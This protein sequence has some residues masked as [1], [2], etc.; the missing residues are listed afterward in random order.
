MLPCGDGTCDNG[1]GEDCET[2]A[3]DCACEIGETCNP[4]SGASGDAVCQ[5]DCNL[6]G[7]PAGDICLHGSC[8]PGPCAAA[9]N[10]DRIVFGKID[11][12]QSPEGGTPNF[13]TQQLAA[14]VASA[15]S[16]PLKSPG[17]DSDD[18]GVSADTKSVEIRK[19]LATCLSLEHRRHKLGPTMGY[20][21]IVWQR[22]GAAVGN[23]L[24]YGAL[25][26]GSGGILLPAPISSVTESGSFQVDSY[27]ISNVPTGIPGLSFLDFFNVDNFDLNS[28]GLNPATI[29][30]YMP[31]HLSIVDIE[32][33]GGGL[34]YWTLTVGYN[35]PVCG[36]DICEYNGGETCDGC[37]E[38]C[39]C[40]A[41]YACGDA[42]TGICTC[43]DNPNDGYDCCAQSEIPVSE[44]NALVE[45][46]HSL[47][48]DNWNST[49]T[50]DSEQWLLTD[51]QPSDWRGVI[52]TNNHVSELVLAW[53]NH[54]GVLP[55]NFNEYPELEV[56]MFANAPLTSGDIPSSLFDL[57]NLREVIIA[58]NG[59]GGELPTNLTNATT[60]E[61][62]WI[63]SNSNLSGKLPSGWS[64]LS[65]LRDLELGHNN[66]IGDI[67]MTF[68]DMPLLEHIVLRDNNFDGLAPRLD[69]SANLQ[70]YSISENNFSGPV[71]SFLT[72]LPNLNVI[73]A[74]SN[75]LAGLV[76][77]DLMT[78]SLSTLSLQNNGCLTAGDNTVLEA[79]LDSMDPNWDNGWT[80]YPACDCFTDTHCPAGDPVCHIASGVCEATPPTC[81][82]NICE[83]PLETCVNC[84][85]DCGCDALETCDAGIG[86]CSC[87]D[88]EASDPDVSAPALVCGGGASGGSCGAGDVD[89]FRIYPQSAA[90]PQAG[91]SDYVVAGADVVCEA[92]AYDIASDSYT[93]LDSDTSPTGGCTLS[94][95]LNPG[96][97]MADV[98]YLKIEG[99]PGASSSAYTINTN[100]A[101]GTPPAAVCGNG[102]VEGTEVCDD[103]DNING[104][105]CMADCSVCSTTSDSETIPYDCCAQTDIPVSECEALV[106]LY[107]DTDGPNWTTNTNWLDSDTVNKGPSTWFGINVSGARVKNI[108][109]PSNNLVNTIPSE[110]ENLSV[111]FDLQLN[112]NSLTGII[113]SWLGNMTAL[114][115]LFL[116]ENNFSGNIPPQIGGLLNLQQLLLFGNS[117]SGT[118]PPEIGD[119]SS[120]TF[121]NLS[122]NNLE[123]LVPPDI[124]AAN[125]PLVGGLHLDR[126]EC[127]TSG[128]NVTLT[129]FLQSVDN[130]GMPW[131]GGFN[132]ET[133]SCQVCGDGVVSGTETC[134]DG[135]SDLPPSDGDGCDANCQVE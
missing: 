31:T 50:S 74:D 133:G 127:L 59:I 7:C 8:S 4:N 99:A 24:G 92:L 23:I 82:D 123:G 134:D 30:Q 22:N 25:T 42:D 84:V 48:G 107:N 106:A 15:Q 131:N 76:P 121:A 102:T 34:D 13:S 72:T 90:S 110:L 45:L 54:A 1:A 37:P 86:Q 71:P 19:G 111:M 27:D 114:R 101:L 73:D 6:G 26:G 135:M 58:S 69:E 116:S 51:S 91:I 53:D 122:L 17:Y 36:N 93:S 124:N 35:D 56:F 18:S 5:D 96:I 33:D 97:P 10:I 100:C 120:L 32:S 129:S 77:A 119:L 103:G 62:I 87:I 43:D 117:L 49:L 55:N 28:M 12:Y 78:L 67:E 14:L 63:H 9:Q 16:A 66:F 38:D 44:C 64:Q 98:Y 47:D 52:V 126:N 88:N 2:C 29:P 70:K 65:A 118:I 104:E 105:G 81:G 57:Q 109:L 94:V 112:G 95:A 41:P 132:D 130:T 39:G 80:G 128:D 125:L 115:Y 83:S 108:G 11:G 40:S 20:G 89:Y 85:A 21:L 68:R 61:R 60:L 113:P 75:L 3:P 46:Y 79:W